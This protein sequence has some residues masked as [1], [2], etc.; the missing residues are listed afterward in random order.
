[1]NS[2][3]AHSRTKN[4]NSNGFYVKPCDG[5]IAVGCAE[6]SSYSATP[7][8]LADSDTRLLQTAVAIGADVEADSETDSATGTTDNRIDVGSGGSSSSGCSIASGT[9]DPLLPPIGIACRAV[10]LMTPQ[11]LVDLSMFRHYIIESSS[12]GSDVVLI[13]VSLRTTRRSI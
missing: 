9:G 7:V 2:Y 6:N 4:A 13:E 3:L 10:F 12:L 1:M 11:L 5:G 8:A